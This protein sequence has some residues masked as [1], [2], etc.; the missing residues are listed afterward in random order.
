MS[1]FHS[2]MSIKASIGFLNP[3]LLFC[4]KIYLTEKEDSKLSKNKSTEVVYYT[5]N[6]THNKLTKSY[7]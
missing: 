2:I 6:I 1:S 4:D 7:K 5:G 3:E